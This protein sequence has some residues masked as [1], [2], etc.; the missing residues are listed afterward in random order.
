[1]KT[2][3]RLFKQDKEGFDVPKS[4]QDTIPITRI[5]KDGIFLY[6]KRHLYF[7]YAAQLTLIFKAWWTCAACF[8]KPSP[9]GFLI[10][11][12]LCDVGVMPVSNPTI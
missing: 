12:G 5:W 7:H 8:W 1:M 4:L 10:L 3:K 2:L 9:P 11:F 6:G